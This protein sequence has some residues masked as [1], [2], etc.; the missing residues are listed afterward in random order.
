MSQPAEPAVR[1]PALDAAHPRQQNERPV[2]DNGFSHVA[3]S[4]ADLDA[5]RHF[6]CDLLGFEE[7]ARPDFGFG[8]MWMAVGDLQL[9][10][11]EVS[12]VTPPGA[13]LPHFALYV[14]T[15][16]F[17][18]VV[19]ALRDAGVPFF[20]PPRSRVD[21]DTTTVWQ[22][23]VSDPSGNVIELTDVGPRRS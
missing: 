3:V 8:G 20:G 16:E 21:F 23:F 19:D 17:P 14:P 6:Y 22:A 13:G 1:P 11:I 15:E 2:F 18:A 7:L 5:A 9:H 12:E 4:V 10:L